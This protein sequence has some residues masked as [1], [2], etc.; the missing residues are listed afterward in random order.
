[1]SAPNEL[2]FLWRVL[3]RECPDD[4]AERVLAVTAEYV[5]EALPVSFGRREPKTPVGDSGKDLVSAWKQNEPVNWRARKPF[6]YGGTFSLGRLSE[7]DVQLG[8]T[9]ERH[10]VGAFKMRCNAALVETAEGY[11]RVRA[12]F[13]AMAHTTS[14][15]IGIV[16]VMRPDG[17]GADLG[18]EVFYGLPTG[19]MWLGYVDERY[20]GL[21]AEH[22]SLESSGDGFLFELPNAWQGEIRTE[23]HSL[24][25]KVPSNLLQ[26]RSERG[27]L[28][29]ACVIPSAFAPTNCKYRGLAYAVEPVRRSAVIEGL[30]STGLTVTNQDDRYIE[31]ASNGW[32]IRL[33]A[34]PL[35]DHYFAQLRLK[36][37]YERPEL[38][39]PGDVLAP[40]VDHYKEMW[41]V[42]GDWD[43]PDGSRFN[44]YFGALEILS[45]QHEH[46]VWIDIGPRN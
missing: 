38:L 4:I 46:T 34:A 5:P 43:E 26:R 17:S 6:G 40:D 30:A 12:F 16:A 10:V 9:L 41:E 7:G 45:R 19:P 15:F 1:M 22:I 33:R 24:V 11:G 3:R 39:Q 42:S 13:A 20:A 37:M 14:S 23:E 35:N 36:G 44:D 31:A 8:G 21:L 29:P 2:T 25:G 18:G 27:Q 32:R 28:A